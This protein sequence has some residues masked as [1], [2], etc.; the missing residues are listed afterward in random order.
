MTDPVSVAAAYAIVL[1]GL[2]IYVA[3]IVRRTRAA[4]R[5]AAALERERAHDRRHTEAAV[6]PDG[7]R[8]VEAPR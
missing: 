5:T 8:S 7:V 2:A 1:G 3:S 4:R 6:V